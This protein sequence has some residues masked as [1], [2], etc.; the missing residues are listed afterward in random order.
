MLQTKLYIPQPRSGLVSRPRLF[1]RLNEGLQRKLTL[2]SAP[3]GFGKTTLVSNWFEQIDV[4]RAWLSLDESDN[5]PA[6]FLTYFVAALQTVKPDIGQGTIAVLN[7]PQPQSPEAVVTTLINDLVT[8][9]NPVAIVLDD[10][11]VIQARSI[12]NALIY[13]LDHCPPQLHLII[14]SRDEPP[15][16]LARLRIGNEL[17]E[18]RATDLAFSSDEAGSFFNEVMGL[19]ISP[20]NATLL[21]NRTEGWIAGLQVVGLSLQGRDSGDQARFIEAFTGSH[22]YVLDYLADEVLNR[23][24]QHIQDFLLQTSI[25][26]RLSDSLCDAVTGQNN[27]QHVLE[28][29]DAANLFLISLDNRRHWYRYHHLF[30]DFLRHLL[31]QRHPDL[32]PQLYHRASHWFEQ[33]NLIDEA[34]EMALAGNDTS[35]AADLIEQTAQTVIWQQGQW[36]TLLHWLEVLPVELV[37]SRPRLCMIHA[38][39]IVPTGDFEAAEIRLQ[40]AEQR[41]EQDGKTA[42]AIGGQV[43]TIRATIARL[44][45]DLATTITLS[46]QALELLPQ[47]E[48]FSRT[49]TALNLGAIYFLGDDTVLAQQM[50]TQAKTEALAANIVT[51]AI[52]TLGYLAQLEV[53]QGRLHRAEALYQQALDLTRQPEYAGQTNFTTGMPYAGLGELYR[54]R[55]DLDTA[56]R[57]LEQ[58]LALAR[59]VNNWLILASVH[60]SLAGVKLAEA[61]AEAAQLHL[62]EAEILANKPEVVWSWIHTPVAAHLIPLWLKQNKI[63][64]ANQTAESWQTQNDAPQPPDFWLEQQNIALTRLVLA[65]GDYAEA[66][67]LLEQLAQNAKATGRQGSFIEILVLQAIAFSALTRTDEALEALEHALQLAE[68]E[69]Y[70]RLFVDEGEHLAPLLQQAVARNIH[71]GYA[72]SLLQAINAEIKVAP[73][74]ASSQL[75]DPLTDRELD[76]LRLIAAGLSNQQIA[77]ELV[78]AHGTV[79]QHIN[80]IYSKLNVKSRTQAILKAQELN[81]V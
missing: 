77:D 80:R 14:A 39:S 34:V 54:E 35:R 62:Q 4:S 6:G 48:A 79:R 59:Q 57:Y 51:L 76:V 17:N 32:V 23:Q 15:F 28:Q 9:S 66:S 69:N 55:N 22:R 49:S 25:L 44:R 50:L 19:D 67:T 71:A 31:Q 63:D 53:R 43:A 61:D 37:N 2:I 70:M 81:L 12:H 29:L 40:Q 68:P 75:L 24:P 7:A 72:G 13:L 64:P 38:W 56:T 41:V 11:H 3:A 45:G 5:D 16:P 20:E 46:Y 10:Y 47:E 33:Y 65:Q 26:N 8:L 21:D 52:V 1:E 18:L 73:A 74:S 60:I 30:Q 36:A 78:I 58:G 27:S 42:E